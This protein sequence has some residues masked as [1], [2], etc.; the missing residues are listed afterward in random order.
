MIRSI[1]L[2][3]ACACLAALSLAAFSQA[4]AQQTNSEELPPGFVTIPPDT[5][6]AGDP[7]PDEETLRKIAREKL[8]KARKAQKAP[9]VVQKPPRPPAGETKQH[10]WAVSAYW[11][12]CN[13][14]GALEGNRRVIQLQGQ[15][16]LDVN[17]PRQ[18]SRIVFSPGTGSKYKTIIC[19]GR[20][21]RVSDPKAFVFEGTKSE[22]ARARYRVRTNFD[23]VDFGSPIKALR[24]YDERGL[25]R[26]RWPEKIYQGQSDWTGFPSERQLN[27]NGKTFVRYRVPSPS[28]Q[29]DLRLHI[30]F[31]RIE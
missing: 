7:S 8:E 31:N 21:Y 9:N 12:T 22:L 20:E 10:K 5:P 24:T 18:R 17:F 26:A 16:R 25:A 19:D 3:G 27:S 6:R 1:T 23:E 15:M 13:S 14:S 11:V 29:P 2:C 30:L 4:H 28:G